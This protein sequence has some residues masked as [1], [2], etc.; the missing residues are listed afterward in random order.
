MGTWDDGSFD[1]DNAL[2]WLDLFT[3]QDTLKPVE[4]AFDVILSLDGDI[5]A[6]YGEEAVSAAEVVALL[7][8]KPAD[9][10]PEDLTKWH[11]SHQLSV[12]DILIA[13]AIQAVEKTIDPKF[14]EL[15]YLREEGK[16][17]PV[18]Y[19][20]ITNLLERLRS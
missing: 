17:F 9:F 19:A 14:S 13:K 4:E 1:N 16:G 18:W 8:R 15:Y 20:N 10:V 6:N 12:D 11:Q 3:S 5:Y 2:D 7:K